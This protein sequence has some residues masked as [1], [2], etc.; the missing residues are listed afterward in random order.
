MTSLQSCTT[1]L[2]RQ[3][4]EVEQARWIYI[5]QVLGNQKRYLANKDPQSNKRPCH[6]SSWAKT[7]DNDERMTPCGVWSRGKLSKRQLHSS[8]CDPWQTTKRMS[9]A[10]YAPL[11]ARPHKGHLQLRPRCWSARPLIL[12]HELMLAGPAECAQRFNN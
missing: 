6:A 1:F 8:S 11:S 7:L 9:S 12:N 10:K 4:V 5:R 3:C 2:R